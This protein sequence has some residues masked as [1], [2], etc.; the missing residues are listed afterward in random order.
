MWTWIQSQWDKLLTFLIS[1]IVAIFVFYKRVFKVEDSLNAHIADDK[2]LAKRL[3]AGVSTI[4]E[5]RVS[6]ARQDVVLT[7]TRVDI[8]ELKDDVR[9]IR[10]DIKKLLSR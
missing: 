1:A 6:T 4:A 5:L 2:E 3:D 9:E 8:K 10:G 7:E